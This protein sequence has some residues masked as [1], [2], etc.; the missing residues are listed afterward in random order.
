[1]AKS[2]S[3]YWVMSVELWESG[4]VVTDFMRDQ[5]AALRDSDGDL[6]PEIARKF[7]ADLVFCKI[8]PPKKGRPIASTA[9]RE[10]YEDRLFMEQVADKPPY[11]Q[12]PPKQ[13]AISSIADELRLSERK[14]SEIVHPRKARKS[15]RGAKT[16]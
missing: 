7:L 10:A 6:L 16:S 9:I 12:E 13:R 5:L 4:A 15:S 11:K 2:K 3:D 1:M 8:K 14:V